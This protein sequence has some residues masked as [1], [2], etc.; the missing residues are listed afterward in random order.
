MASSHTAVNKAAAAMANFMTTGV[1]VEPPMT[2][3][4][5]S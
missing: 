3:V 2:R 5:N 4:Y 1:D